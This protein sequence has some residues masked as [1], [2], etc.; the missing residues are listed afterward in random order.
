MPVG[1]L[2][3]G[4]RHPGRQ[5]TTDKL[6]TPTQAA[7]FARL[8]LAN[9]EREFPNKLDHVMASAADVASPRVLHPAFFGSFDW[10]SC[11]HAH[12]LLARILR[13][14]PDIPEAALIRTMLESH[15]CA[16]NVEAEVA[17][18]RRPE[19]HAF[20]RPYGWAW[21]LKLAQELACWS[22][23]DAHCWSQNLAPLAYVFSEHFGEWLADASY[24]IRHGV[25]TNTAFALAF[26]LDYARDCDSE[27]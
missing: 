4:G 17:Y 24:P 10:H 12:W 8:A 5:E 22:D 27:V 23:A 21:L 11:V 26:A 16:A 19:S 20:E 14:Q 25:H 3:S 9:V 13:L 7:A 6:L 15:L 1:S 18:F 2:S